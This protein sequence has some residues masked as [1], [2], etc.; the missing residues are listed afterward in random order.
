MIIKYYEN[1]WTMMQNVNPKTKKSFVDINWRTNTNAKK[2][3]IGRIWSKYIPQISSVLDYGG[4]NRLTG[5]MLKNLGYTGTYEVCDLAKDINAEYQNIDEIIKKYD[6]ITCFQIIEHMYFEDFL[7]LMPKLT[8]LI[9]PGGYLAIS[10]DNPAHPNHLWNVQMGHL[11]SYPY[12]DLHKYLQTIGYKYDASEIVLQY[13]A[14]DTLKNKL[15]YK[16]RK[17]CSR[18]LGFDCHH[19]YIIFMQKQ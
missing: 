19:S 4:G 8:S 11:K 5:E 1:Y 16:I 7:E 18:I 13:V 10:S 9:N 15:L 12:T 14:E 6:L 3:R 2:M 17:S